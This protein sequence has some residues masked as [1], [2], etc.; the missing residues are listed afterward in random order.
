MYHMNNGTRNNIAEDDT[1]AVQL[2]ENDTF[3]MFTKWNN[4]TNVHDFFISDKAR[5]CSF[6]IRREQRKI[7][8]HFKYCFLTYM[9]L[10]LSLA[11]MSLGMFDYDESWRRL[12][13]WHSRNHWNPL[14]SCSWCYDCLFASMCPKTRVFWGM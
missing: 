11:M 2:H 10:Q 3:E 12:Y 9:Q 6:F 8:Y 14:V 13:F 1:T 5:R 4:L 7:F